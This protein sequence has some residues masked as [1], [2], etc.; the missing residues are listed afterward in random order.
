MLATKEI[1]I[2]FQSLI[3]D[4]HFI[5]EDWI[6]AKNGYFHFSGHLLLSP[7]YYKLVKD[8]LHKKDPL[9]SFA[10]LNQIDFPNPNPNLGGLSVSYDK[11][12]G[13]TDSFRIINKAGVQIHP[14]PTT[15]EPAEP[16]EPNDK[17]DSLFDDSW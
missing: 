10:V 6:N 15:A 2:T 14:A 4:N 5:Q 17:P 7:V 11:H 3:N 1:I 8:E 12:E 9:L 16:A 13:Q